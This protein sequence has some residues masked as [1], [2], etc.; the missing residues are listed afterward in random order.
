MV[1]VYGYWNSWL[2]IFQQAGG[3]EEARVQLLWLVPEIVLCVAT[4][5]SRAIF[6]NKNSSFLLTSD[7]TWNINMNTTEMCYCWEQ[8]CGIFLCQQISSS[9]TPVTRGRS[10]LIPDTGPRHGSHGHW[11]WPGYTDTPQSPAQQNIRQTWIIVI[12]F[13]SVVT[14]GDKSIVV[15]RTV[16]AKYDLGQDIHC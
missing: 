8:D 1:I 15:T 16:T 6:A 14:I 2:N 12:N 11:Y 3:G 13:I 5:N 10:D 4:Q 7:N 9:A